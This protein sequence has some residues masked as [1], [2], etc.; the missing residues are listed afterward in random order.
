MH[1]RDL[2]ELAGLAS[3]H[4]PLVIASPAALPQTSLERYWSASK[5]RLDRWG[6]TLK[7][8]TESTAD[9]DPAGQKRHDLGVMEEVLT[10]EVL[11]RVWTAV[12]VGH[13]RHAGSDAGTVARS[14][15]V[16]QQEARNRALSLLV[17]GPAI[18]GRPAIELNQLRRRAE[19]WSDLLVGYLN[20]TEDLSEFGADPPRA[21]QFA[22]DF[23]DEGTHAWSLLFASLR[24]SFA[25]GFDFP[26][27][28][29]DLNTEI[30][31]SI[32]S[33][34]APELFDS[35]G[36]VRSLWASRLLH[37]TNETQGLIE[38]LFCA[39]RGTGEDRAV[40]VAAE[41]PFPRRRFPR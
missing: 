17:N 36:L 9:K 15:L 35:T 3:M 26:S 32:I 10:G 27:P 2:V 25:H 38:A 24:A 23:R 22:D 1:A 31:T 8:L 41:R 11:V 40:G 21:R 16:G 13:D 20:T 5:C 7:R 34:F 4:G 18:G 19:C 14:V 6:R 37:A 39:E 30:A 29:A 33:C 28:N 12:L